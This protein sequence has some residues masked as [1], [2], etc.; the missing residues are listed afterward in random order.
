MQIFVKLLPDITITLNVEQ[1]DTI[2]M[3]KLLLDTEKEMKINKK[4][5]AK[6]DNSQMAK[7]RKIDV[8]SNVINSDMKDFDIPI[9]Y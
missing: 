3:I 1:F 8:E 2:D 9:D 6:T 7:R 5:S 4:R